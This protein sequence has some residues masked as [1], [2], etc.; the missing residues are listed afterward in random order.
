MVEAEASERP[1]Y[2]I[3]PSSTSFFSS[4]I[5]TAYTRKELHNSTMGY[6]SKIWLN[7]PTKL[8]EGSLQKM[9]RTN[10]DFD[11]KA[12]VDAVLVIEIDAIH[13]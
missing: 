2:F 1:M 9:R 5:Y 4:P 12:G 11:G 3:L 7:A 8:I 6:L 10:R 13:V